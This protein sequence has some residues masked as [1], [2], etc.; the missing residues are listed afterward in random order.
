[1]SGGRASCKPARVGESPGTV[2]SPIAELDIDSQRVTTVL[3]PTGTSPLPAPAEQTTSQGPA[4]RTPRRSRALLRWV[5]EVGPVAL[6]VLGVLVFFAG[7][8]GA[9]HIRVP[10][11]P[12]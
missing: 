4:E 12:D 8:F 5:G 10:V 11:G 2:E 9:R 1:G 7:A 3:P 6:A